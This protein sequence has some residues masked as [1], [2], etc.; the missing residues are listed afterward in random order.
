MTRGLRGRGYGEGV[1]RLRFW[2][3]ALLGLTLP[4]ALS[5][6]AYFLSSVSL[7]GAEP[8]PFPHRSLGQGNSRLVTPSE[9]A[10]DG[11]SRRR[12]REEATPTPGPT[13]E[14]GEDVSG[15]CDEAEHAKDPECTSGGSDDSSGR[16]SSDSSE[17]SSG[18]S[19]WSG[20]SGSGKSDDD[21]SG[22]G[23]GD[24][25]SEPGDD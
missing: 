11:G 6:A 19:E 10:E 23:S 12:G 17:S 21:R 5:F 22:S 7:G 1:S 4:V 14:P 8:L 3:L 20:S 16:G 24:D 2:A 25:S 9:D 15:N 18:S 13:E